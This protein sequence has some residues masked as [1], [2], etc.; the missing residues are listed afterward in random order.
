MPQLSERLNT[1]I[2]TEELE[3]RWRLVREAMA[4]DGIDVLVAQTN[5]DHMGGTVKYLTDN[6]A[7][8]GYPVT[9]VFPR[10]DDMTVVR[11]GPFDGVTD[12][13]HE[14]NGI[15]R[16]VRRI[17]TMPYFVTA[18][19]TASYDAD[20]A[21]QALQ[22][23][24]R[25]RIGLV[26]PAQMSHALAKHLE[27]SLPG[28]TFVDATDMLDRVKAIRSEEEL[29]LIRRTARLQDEALAAAFAAIEPGMRDSDVVAVA[30]NRCQ[31][32][33]SEQGIFLCASGPVGT[34]MRLSPRHH[35]NRVL[36]EGDQFGLLIETNGPGGF[37]AEIGRTFVLGAIPAKLEDEFAFTLEAR[38]VIL[39]ALVPG[40]SPAEVF[41]TYTE[42]M[43]ARGRPEDKRLVGHAQGYDMVERSLIRGD[44]TMPLADRMNMAVHPTY[45]HKEMMS[46][47]CDN[48]ILAA[49]G[50]PERIH[51]TEERLFS[52]N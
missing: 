15:W 17:L 42:F 35:Q 50:S 9:V 36:R 52:F 13:P 10:E 12:L 49:D 34:P 14:G 37:Y 26:G 30:M 48:Y 16:G 24:A 41:A 22:P 33:G 32:G 46:W 20:L 39:S 11:Q 2:S 27:A 21:A 43:T 19:Y 1:P 18:G 8:N 5:N 25:G 45:I 7:S 28:A 29:Q 23:F 44:E 40:A 31:R 38:D 47:V 6:P 4:R 51:A 3:R